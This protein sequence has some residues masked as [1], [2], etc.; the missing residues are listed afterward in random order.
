MAASPTPRPTRASVSDNPALAALRGLALPLPAAVAFSGGA[1][2]TAL[3][4]AACQ[5]WPGR[6]HAIHI[7][8]GLQARADDFERHCQALCNELDVPLHVLRV[9]AGHRAGE[10]PE[11]AARKARYTALAQIAASL[12]MQAVLLGHHADDQVETMLLALSR[13][14]GLPGLAAMP[15][16]FERHGMGF[17]RPL[18]GIAAKPLREWLAGQG[19]AVIDDPTNADIAF[20]RNRIRHEILPALDRSFPHF[21]ETFARSARHMAQAQ[22][23]LIELAAGDLSRVGNPPLIGELRRLSRARQANVLRHWLRTACDAAATTAQ[24]EELLDQVEACTTRGHAIGMKVAAGRVELRQ[25]VLRYITSA[26]NPA[27]GE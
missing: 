17:W 15:K 1:D 11:D 13:G 9:K 26:Q 25:G 22:E 3:L 7:H 24:M 20:T 14:A 5:V 16:C 27:P 6:I 12:G 19:Q 8:H 10:S 2:S 23:L 18:L 21:R 4:M